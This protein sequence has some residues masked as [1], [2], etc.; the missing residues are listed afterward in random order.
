MKP[1]LSAV[2][3]A[4]GGGPPAVYN[5]RASAGRPAPTRSGSVA[6][7]KLRVRTVDLH[8]ADCATRL[9]FRFG[10]VTLARAPQC[11]ARV[12]VETEGGERAE[13][14]SADLLPPRWFR[15]DPAR[16][17]RQDVVDLAQ[18][19]RA[20]A[21]CLADPRSGEANVFG[22]WR[23]VYRERVDAVPPDAG[24][25]LVR[26]FGVALVE[27]ALIDA[28]CRAAGLSFFDACR[29]DLLGFRPA[30]IL[31][32]LGGWDVA[33]SLPL[34]PRPRVRVR[35]TVGLLDVLRSAEIDP[36]QRVGDGLPQAL[37]EDIAAYGVDAFKIKLCGRR[38]LDRERLLAIARLLAERVAP[39][40]TITLDANEQYAELAELAALF[41]D[42]DTDADGRRLMDGLA[43]IEQPLPRAASFDPVR[44][45]E[46]AALAER[47]PPVLDEADVGTEAFPRAVE[48]GW[49]G[50]SVKS[51]KGVF[52]ALL[53]RGV[54]ALRPG[55]VQ[56]A[57]DLTTLPV[58][59]LQQDLA[60]VAA[61]DLPHVERNG[62]HYF[63]GLSHLS[64][65]ERAAAVARHPR[66]YRARSGGAFVA[67]ENGEIDLSDLGGPGFGHDVT[68]DLAARVP[69]ERWEASAP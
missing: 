49:R 30:E 23:R 14:F 69:I 44:T 22:H 57:E 16:S 31:P 13:G 37:E 3:G 60:L 26:G 12:A 29:Q 67:I 4:V 39:P 45:R 54:C 10:V 7:L 53:N 34:S 56:T 35:H 20:A 58:H 40:W 48:L 55:L 11:T 59:A 28:A 41:A 47:A 32:E 36:A 18:S 6:P 42:L 19:A 50:V 52:R 65:A 27:R 1:L 64:E 46:L 25:R 5:P 8:M 17:L 38:E 9:P 21:A 33:A 63:H 51:C 68:P 2:P 43:A 15:K 24:D 66:L 62:H 61:L